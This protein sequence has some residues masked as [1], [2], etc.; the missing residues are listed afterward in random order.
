ME[1]FLGLRFTKG[2]KSITFAL[3]LLFL[4]QFLKND[5]VRLGNEKRNIHANFAL[6]F[7]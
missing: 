1:S 5:V 7:Y 2:K 4:E 3:Q 6:G